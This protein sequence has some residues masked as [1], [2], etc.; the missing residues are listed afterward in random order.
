MQER[1]ADLEL[2]G[3]GEEEGGLDGVHTGV[4]ELL[5]ARAGQEE[6]GEA[7]LLEREQRRAVGV[8]GGKYDPPVAR[9]FQD[10]LRWG[11]LDFKFNV[12]QALCSE[13]KLHGECL[14]REAVRY[15]GI[16]PKALCGQINYFEWWS[17]AD[18]T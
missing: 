5:G 18:T 16:L 7:R 14:Q 3:L 8:E 10:N 17:K 1:S 2:G 12:E 4:W 9:L 13:H 11:V 6:D 15:C